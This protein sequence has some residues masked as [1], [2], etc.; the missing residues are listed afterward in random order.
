[1]DW[2]VLT[3][4]VI[5]WFYYM[6]NCNTTFSVYTLISNLSAATRQNFYTFLHCPVPTILTNDFML[7]S[8]FI[9][10]R[11]CLYCSCI[12]IHL[13]FLNQY[14]LACSFFWVIFSSMSLIIVFQYSLLSTT[15]LSESYVFTDFFKII[16]FLLLYFLWFIYTLVSLCSVLFLWEKYVYVV[17]VSY[18]IRV[19]LFC[20]KN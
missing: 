18:W 16:C 11:L 12:L 19:Q 10:W 2:I 8:N 20:P 9:H 7:E 6:I 1:M 5:L 17:N 14:V 4:K 15:I 3:L 13:F